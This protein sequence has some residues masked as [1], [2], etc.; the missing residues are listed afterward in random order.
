M[1]DSDVDRLHSLGER[2]SAQLLRFYLLST[3]AR[4]RIVP[5]SHFI[6]TDG[7]HG[8]SLPDLEA[9]TRRLRRELVPLFNATTVAVVPGFYGGAASTGEITTFGRGGSDL[10]AAIVGY[11]VDASVV[12][13]FKVEHEREEG[14]W[15][16]GSWKEGL[17]GIVHSSA[18]TQTIERVSYKDAAVMARFGKK[19]LHPEAV[20]PVLE[21]QIPLRVANTLAPDEA[22]TLIVGDD[23][24]ADIAVVDDAAGAAD[25]SVAV[26]AATRKLAPSTIVSVPMKKV[27]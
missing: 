9:T 6:V 23:A 24:A 20:F 14:T 3:G 12:T 1:S 5:P 10:T 4:A 8:E 21:K 15:R 26:M 2:L 18:K 16:M 19:V 22:G 7:R 27:S 11:A 13:L 25:E 17:V